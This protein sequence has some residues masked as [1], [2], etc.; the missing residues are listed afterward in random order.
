MR[1]NFVRT[2]CA[3]AFVFMLCSHALLAGGI[4][5]L[6]VVYPKLIQ[7]A[8]T[9]AGFV[10]QGW[11]I[12]AEV[13]GDLNSDKLPDVAFVLHE[14]RSDNIWDASAEYGPKKFDTNPRILVVAFSRPGGGYNIAV[15]NHTL[16]PRMTEPSAD[17]YF[18]IG[19]GKL[20]IKRG[21]LQVL[22]SWDYGRGSHGN[23]TYTFQF[24]KMQFELV[25]YDSVNV[26]RGSGEIEMASM[27]Y[28]T[29]KA[30][31]S[32]GHVDG[33]RFPEKVFWKKIEDG[34]LL[35]IEQVGDGIRFNR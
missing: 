9:S 5:I 25:G 1:V 31:L 24:R 26:T 28:L 13:K 30:K 4:K 21:A 23:V 34:P 18:G 6:P 15:E 11:R 32:S 14:T 12:E 10:P 35:T 20:E 2:S 19:N 8:Q 7:R 27:N 33:A 16:I 29:H 3:C 22:L 17:D